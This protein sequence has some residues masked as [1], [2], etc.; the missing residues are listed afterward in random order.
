MPMSLTL[1]V[2]ALLFTGLSLLAVATKRRLRPSLSGLFGLL[3]VLG[4][5]LWLSVE[6]P[7][8]ASLWQ[9]QYGGPLLHCH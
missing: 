1:A 9:V 3:L 6:A 2:L 4:V 7:L 8:A 5:L